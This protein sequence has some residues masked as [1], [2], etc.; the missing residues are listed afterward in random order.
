MMKTMKERV[1]HNRNIKGYFMTELIKR[2]TNF[3][4]TFFFLA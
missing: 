4:R 1:K 3:S 2:V